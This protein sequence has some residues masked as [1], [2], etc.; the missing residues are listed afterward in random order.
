MLAQGQ[1]PDPPPEHPSS[2]FPLAKSKG[3]LSDM[4]LGLRT[5]VTNRISMCSHCSGLSL[6]LLPDENMSY[7]V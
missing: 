6:V 4:H 7:W 5:E 2:L 3:G 1:R